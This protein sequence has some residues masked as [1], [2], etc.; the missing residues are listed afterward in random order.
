[1]DIYLVSFLKD[2]LAFLKTNHKISPCPALVGEAFQTAGLVSSSCTWAFKETRLSPHIILYFRPFNSTCWLLMSLISIL[3]FCSSWCPISFSW[4]PFV[5]IQI[6][7]L[8]MLLYGILDKHL[9]QFGPSRE[10]LP[11][12]SGIMLP[13]G[14]IWSF[15]P[16]EHS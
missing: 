9:A 12:C 6:L 15:P 7:L 2:V 14:S 8:V 5:V 1:M 13:V 3:L 16:S 11:H 10:L 4:I